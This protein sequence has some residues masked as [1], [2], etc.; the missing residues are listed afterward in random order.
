[1]NKKIALVIAIVVA[2]AGLGFAYTVWRNS[3]PPV[4]ARDCA[5]G[6]TSVAYTTQQ[7]FLPACIKVASGTTVTYYNQSD[8]TLEVGTDPHPIH[9]GN[10][11]VSDGK[12]TLTIEPGRNA[13]TTLTTKGTFGLHDHKNSY[14]RAVLVVE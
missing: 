7:S 5:T 2:L 6:V 1:M 3:K 12:F 11:E 10:R 13:T 14:A 8:K 9:N 4:V